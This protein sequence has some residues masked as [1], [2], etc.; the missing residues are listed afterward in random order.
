MIKEYYR[1]ETIAE[2]IR[3]LQS[4]ETNSVPLAGGTVLS[5]YQRDPIS[6]VDLQKLN[7]NYVQENESDYE[8]GA[9][10]TLSQ[11]EECIK[12]P[13]LVDVIRLQAGR[14]KRNS[15]TIGG[16]VTMADGRS[17]LLAALLA[18]DVKMVWEPENLNISLEEWLLQRSKWQ[19]ASLIIKFIL[20][21]VS[22]NFESIARTP[23]DLPILCI[24][25]TKDHLDRIRTV[26][27]G[28]GSKPILAYSGNDLDG[29]SNAIEKVL[30]GSDDK[31][32]SAAYR[33][34]AGKALALRL[35]AELS[36]KRAK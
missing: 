36:D 24:A 27:G 32:A 35:A 13:E 9:T 31:W 22:L 21:K 15:G 6:V 26:I 28:F 30:S 19:E 29:I 16:L 11:I 23:K 1:P 7:L 20:P 4:K 2:A 5:H 8:I 12:F 25:I 14:N 17:P 34:K 33:Q 18:L 3:L 10:A